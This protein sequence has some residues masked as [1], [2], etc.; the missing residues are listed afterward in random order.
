MRPPNLSRTPGRA[1]CAPANSDLQTRNHTTVADPGLSVAQ[2]LAIALFYLGIWAVIGR[3]Q[4]LQHDA[5]IYVLQAVALLQPDVFAGDLYLKYGSQDRFTLFS[6]FCAPWIDAFGVDHGAAAL[7]FGFFALWTWS[8]WLLIKHLAGSRNAWLAMGLLLVFPGWYGAG[9][10]FEVS[11]LFLSARLPAE[12]VSLLAIVAVIRGMR[13][14][15]VALLGVALVI[16][17]LMTLPVIITLGVLLFVKSDSWKVMLP[18]SLLLSA[19]C[20]IAGAVLGGSQPQMSDDWLSAVRS[21]SNF[22][23]V[24]NWSADD[25]QNAGL[26][27]MTAAIAVQFSAGDWARRICAAALCTATAGLL[28]TAFVSLVL[29]LRIVI[30]GQPW[31]WIW[32]VTLLAIAL[33][34][35]VLRLMWVTSD[36]GKAAAL[37]LSAA[38]LMNG[39][40]AD[41]SELTALRL[42]FAAVAVA[43]LVF[44]GKLPGSTAALLL[45]GAWLVV[46]LCLLWVASIAATE[47]GLDFDFGGDPIWIQRFGGALLSPAVAA[48]AVLAGWRLVSG[49][50]NRAGTLVVA[51]IGVA[52]ALGA[53]PQAWAQWSAERFGA[54]QRQEFDAWRDRIQPDQEV[55]WPDGLQPTWF[56]LERRS[57]LSL[58]QLGGIVFSEDLSSEARRRAKALEEIFPPESWFYGSTDAANVLDSADPGQL[59]AACR[60]P[61]VAYFVSSI[62]LDAKA[63]PAEWPTKGMFVY[64]HDCSQ[65]DANRT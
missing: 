20:L 2:T 33:L 48:L 24:D 37:L 32:I 28:A 29:P 38:W 10:V 6:N 14:L 23:F 7:T 17:P 1:R 30:Q 51:T 50:M 47:S 8:A 35:R 42:P 12:A 3:Y 63:L 62:R 22:L 18:V 25:W 9:R 49:R 61:G 65:T 64:L 21:R 4:G 52:L 41:G 16:H 45:R 59:T 15:S 31:R 36:A 44:Q 5:Q 34:P 53:A 39:V 19:A 56:V 26:V 54:Q 11:E 46:G 57:Y 27:L 55:L 40:G 58:S 60:A 13:G 43:M